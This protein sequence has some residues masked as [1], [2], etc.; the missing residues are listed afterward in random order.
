MHTCTYTC[1]YISLGV[2][3]LGT[4]AAHW[5]PAEQVIKAQVPT[6]WEYSIFYSLRVF[7][8]PP[9]LS[10]EDHLLDGWESTLCEYSIAYS[11]RVF[12]QPPILSVEDHLLDGWESTLWEYNL[13]SGSIV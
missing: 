12:S 6:L 7:T 10:V 5:K 11:L 3:T 13:L 4:W 2:G 9:V 8:Q 1:T